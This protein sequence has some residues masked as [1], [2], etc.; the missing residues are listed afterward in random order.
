[1]AQVIAPDLAPVSN[2]SHPRLAAAAELARAADC[3]CIVTPFYNTGPVFHDTAEYVFRQT[4]QDWEWLIVDD[5]STDPQALALLAHY[6]ARD[7]RVRVIRHPQNRGLSAARNTGVEHCQT[8]YFLQLDADDLIEPTFIEKCL[9]ALESHTEW[10]FCNAWS[11]GFGSKEFMWDRGFGLGRDFLAENQVTPTA[12]IRRKAD[13]DIGGHDESIRDGLE[14]WDY[15]LK[16]A[17]HGYWGGTLPEYLTRYR[18]HATPTF[19]PNRDDPARKAAFRREM[20]RRYP[21]LW[22]RGGFPAPQA[23]A[24]PAV[25]E[26]LPFTGSAPQAA[27]A[28]RILMLVPWFS[29]GGAD[30]FNLSLAQQL[31]RRGCAVTLCATTAGP[32][33]WLPAFTRHVTDYF[34]LPSFLQPEDYP[35][36]LRYLIRARQADIVL[37]SNSM[38]GYS[39]LP[40]LRAHCPNTVF[41]DYNHMVTEWLQGGF[42]RVGLNCQGGLDLSIVSCEHVKAWMV[43]RGADAQRVEVCHINVDVQTWDASRFDRADLRRR[44]QLPEATPVLI[45]PARIE[46]QKRPRVLVEILRGLQQAHPDFLC[47]IAGDGLQRPW[48]VSALAR[49]GLK[50]RTRLLGAVDPDRMPEL[51]AAADVLL[52]PSQDEGISLAIYEAMAMGV[53]P[54]VADVGGQ[55]ELV[56]AETGFLVPHGPTEVDE[57]VQILS[58]LC[59][60]PGLRQS[61]G[62]AAR[63][64]VTAD[65]AIEQ[66]AERMPRL[67]DAARRYAGA[68]PRP[69]LGVAAAHDLAVQVVE[70][71]RFERLQER[72]R[73][74]APL[75]ATSGEQGLRGRWHVLIYQVK[76]RLFRPFYYWAL[77]SGFDP[78][79]PLANQAY[80]R[81]SWLLR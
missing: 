3:I 31:T 68:V 15:W 19:W 55:R 22:Q 30:R 32:H 43:E 47:L 2:G 26:A 76:R 79:V 16:M 44:W 7:S 48:L 71:L 18:H 60:S 37:I 57:Y 33:P 9:W 13:R 34:L 6:A 28:A 20:R 58:R 65:F 40:Y 75:S 49:Y 12:V 70:D 78:I 4:Y 35:R 25:G 46:P 5:G 61:V 29:L 42:A 17:A 54:V 1:M 67:F 23:P 77:R 41:V 63:Q 66:M 69:R 24:S 14:D 64:H 59:A 45:Y 81:L 21:A 27:A 74:D 73:S 8:P 50:K 72:L 51:M 11:I 39:L 80:R 38:L 62:R 56:T 36:F 52:L 53:V 10:S